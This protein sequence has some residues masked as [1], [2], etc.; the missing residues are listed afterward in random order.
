MSY[1]G[2]AREYRPQK[3]EKLIG[4][5]H[6]CQTLMNSLSSQTV[7]SA[8]LFSG[9]RG[10]GK[11]TTARILA[12]A[13]NCEKN[14]ESINEPCDECSSC[15][16]I[17]VSSHPDVLEIDG[18][19]YTGVENVRDLQEGLVYLPS[20]GKY[21]CIILDEVHMLSKGAFNA[22]LKTLEEPPPNVVFIF[23]TTELRRVPE[24][25]IS[26]CQTFE[27]R[28]ISIKKISEHLSEVS[29][30]RGRELEES[31]IFS[32]SRMSEGS[33][34]DALSLLDQILS[35]SEK[36][37]IVQED[38]ETVLGLPPSN[39]YSYIL[40]A[41]S[42]RNTSNALMKLKDIYE[43]GHDLK[44]FSVGL[45]NYLR[46]LMV[47]KVAGKNEELFD[48]SKGE[49]AEREE[50]LSLFSFEEVHHAYNILNGTISE[51][52]SLSS[53]Y[54]ILE[55]AFL[56]MCNMN[57]ISNVDELLEQIKHSS[58][59]PKKT[60]PAIV[61]REIDIKKKQVDS[62][63]T[64]QEDENFGKESSSRNTFESPNIGWDSSKV[65]EAWMQVISKL[66][67][68]R[69]VLFDNL[70]TDF[71]QSNEIKL[72]INSSDGNPQ[73]LSIIEEELTSLTEKLKE[74][75]PWNTKI[76]LEKNVDTEIKNKKSYSN[77]SIENDG[78]DM[79]QEV[80]DLF[81][82]K[83]VDIKAHEKPL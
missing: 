33:V 18:A 2:S 3:F 83:V 65:E 6:I 9:T 66:R 26:R 30:L 36:D 56:R 46:D 14:G 47:L 35:F 53:P 28:R 23:A 42:Q 25:V 27:F 80:V 74:I 43:Q 39:V 51:A 61:P 58:T 44:V 17:S 13:L 45:L 34:R 54:F 69:R 72:L 81:D 77:I 22:L 59:E 76:T 7:A 78:K 68:S 37:K 60:E 29:K 55:I 82:G 70:T 67:E 73:F 19:T 49:I 10:V 15:H 40:T 24:T 20:K 62:L 75:I 52:S 8:Y 16:E 79:I 1:E 57:I 71:S 38:I 50:I 64:F 31:V 32:I 41:V 11:T 4:Q 48:I 63:N 21:K 12:K 5:E